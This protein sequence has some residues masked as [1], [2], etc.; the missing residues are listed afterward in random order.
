VAAMINLDLDIRV[1][2][3]PGGS[4]KVFQGPFQGALCIMYIEAISSGPGRG[5]RSRR[6]LRLLGCTHHDSPRPCMWV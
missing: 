1:L 4:T 2:T 3:Y 5:L 6:L